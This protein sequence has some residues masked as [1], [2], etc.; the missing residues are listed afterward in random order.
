MIVGHRV[1]TVAAPA[2]PG[3]TSGGVE[4]P[5]VNPAWPDSPAN[6]VARAVSDGTTRPS[7]R[8]AAAHSMATSQKL[9]AAHAAAA[10]LPAPG[11]ASPAAAAASARGRRAGDRVPRRLQALRSGDVGLDQATFSVDRGEFVFLVGSTGSGKSTVMRLLIKELEPTERHDPG[12]R[13]RPRRDH[14]ASGCRTTAATS[15]WSSRTSSCCRTGPCTTTSPTRSRSPA[16]RARRSAAKVP[17]I[18][19]LTGLSTKLHNY[20]GPALRRRAAA[21]LDRARVRQ[22]PA[23]AAGRRADRQPRSRDQHRHHA[24]ALP[25]QPHRHDRAGG[26]PRPG[27]GRQDAPPRARALPR[28]DRPRRGHRPVH[29]RRDHARVRPAA[30]RS[31]RPARRGCSRCGSAS[32]CA[33]RCARCAA[34]PRRASPRWP[35]CW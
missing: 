6:R 15:A 11:S 12:R 19:R 27:D 23:A 32:S 29:A 3:G 14:R 34:A 1:T 20:P 24:A 21:R 25:D 30:A 4:P 22:P 10:P 31:P 18:L 2:I 9:T 28:A 33:R 16:A 8:Y 17:D 13:P 7:A 26:H 5:A 35:P